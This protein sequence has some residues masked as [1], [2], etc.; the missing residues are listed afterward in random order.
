M[1][2]S[3][4]VFADPCCAAMGLVNKGDFHKCDVERKKPASRVHAYN[5]HKI[6]LGGDESEVGG[7]CVG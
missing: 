3:T 2:L 4:E 1:T 5:P 6:N 7:L